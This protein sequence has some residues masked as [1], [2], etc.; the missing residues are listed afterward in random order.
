MIGDYLEKYTFEYLIDSALSRVSDSI[1]KREGSIIYDALAP[2]CYE[3]AEVYMQLRSILKDTFAETATDNYLDLRVAE[4]GIERYQATYA[5]K[6]A[7]FKTE[8]NAPV[9]IEI[10]SRFSTVSDVASLTYVVTDNYYENNDVVEGSYKL[11][12][13]TV[14]SIGNIYVGNLI[15]VD[16]VADL[17]SAIMTDLLVPARDVETDDELRSRYFISWRTKSFGGNVAQ[18]DEMLKD[19]EGVG[20][21]QIYSAW[22][23]GGTV[24]ASVIDAQLNPISQPFIDAIQNLVDPAPEGTGVG[25]APIGHTVTITTPSTVTVDIETTVTLVSGVELSQVE[26]PIKDA[27]EAYMHELRANWGVANEYNVHELAVYISKVN[28]TIIVVPGV[29]NVTGTLINN[30]NN[31]L[32]LTQTAAIQELPILG[33]VVLNE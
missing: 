13:E 30:I 14:G 23:G 29:A 32:V 11:T 9:T 2:A 26:Q 6:K 4:Q 21:A 24:K 3:L 5:T 22:N 8:A 31:D 7:I 18:Y 19:I 20:E 15:P 16:Y 28:A 1:D 12:C 17:G 10:G 33:E 25:L 27:L